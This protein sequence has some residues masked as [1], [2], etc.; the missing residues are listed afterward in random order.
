MHYNSVQYTLKKKNMYNF[1][2]IIIQ[3]KVVKDD[4]KCIN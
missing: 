2:R 4:Q 1:E 3:H